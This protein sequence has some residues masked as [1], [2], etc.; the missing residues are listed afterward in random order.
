M[1]GNFTFHRSGRD[2]VAMLIVAAALFGLMALR[3]LFE[4]HW[5]LL[6]V[7][8]IPVLPALRDIVVDSPA[9]L[10]MDPNRLIWTTG[11]R[12]GTVALEEIDH[13]RFDRRWDFSVR[14]TLV[15]KL[16]DKR[17]RLPDECLPRRKELATAFEARGL[18]VRWTHFTVF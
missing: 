2:T 1:T 3:V 10:E 15:L 16:H 17:I 11:S 9:G 18:A 5:I 12:T 6:L 14:V 4:A 7:L 13:V 8:A